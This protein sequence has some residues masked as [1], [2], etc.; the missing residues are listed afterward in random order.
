MSEGFLKL[1][2]EQVYRSLYRQQ[3]KMHTKGV[4]MQSH[5]KMRNMLLE[6]V[7][8]DSYYKIIDYLAE[9]CYLEYKTRFV[10]DG[11]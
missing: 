9:L 10:R 7:Q 2:V 8:S 3:F 5:T 4:F 11:C 6:T 1:L